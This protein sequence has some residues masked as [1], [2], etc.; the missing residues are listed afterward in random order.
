[1]S[2]I[3]FKTFSVTNKKAAAKAR[4]WYSLDNRCD[5]RKCVTIYDRDYGH[6]LS[7]VFAGTPAEYKN[8][9]DSMTD[10]FDKGRVVIFE[11]DSLYAEARKAV[12]AVL[13]KE[14]AKREQ[15]HAA[16]LARAQQC[17]PTFYGNGTAMRS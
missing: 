1:M 13:A 12:E 5:G 2:D 7:K 15:R 10:Y 8:D 3:N 14:A 17:R 11:G 16:R 4:V 6:A 9:T